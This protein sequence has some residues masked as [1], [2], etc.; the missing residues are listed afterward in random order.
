ML[1]MPNGTKGGTTKWC[2]FRGQFRKPSDLQDSVKDFINFTI[3]KRIKKTKTEI[4]WLL[5]CDNKINKVNY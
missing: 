5:N 4:E 2:I 3:I 1:K